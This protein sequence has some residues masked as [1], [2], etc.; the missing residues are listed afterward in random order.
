VLKNIGGTISLV[1]SLTSTTPWEDVSAWDATVVAD[2]ANDAL[3][4]KVTGAASTNIRWVASVRTVEVT[5]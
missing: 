5:Y 1:G 3:E 4:V 2:D